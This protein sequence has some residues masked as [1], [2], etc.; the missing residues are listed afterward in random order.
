M[1]DSDR[2]RYI[3]LLRRHTTEGRLTLDEFSDRVG[4]VYSAR[5]FADLDRTL[6]ELPVEPSPR[7]KLPVAR[8]ARSALVPGGVLRKV[9]LVML[10]I[11]IISSIAFMIPMIFI[12]GGVVCMTR[13]SRHHA[14]RT[15][16]AHPRY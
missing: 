10:A 4:E 5:T 8:R 1:S 11:W 7:P 2:E 6:R 13:K 3:A 16:H 15:A 12:I 14:W 9:A